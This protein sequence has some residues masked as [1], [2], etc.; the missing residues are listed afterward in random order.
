MTRFHSL[1]A[2]AAISAVS[3]PP[4]GSAQSSFDLSSWGTVDFYCYVEG[5]TSDILHLSHVFGLQKGDIPRI[6]PDQVAKIFRL[7]VAVNGEYDVGTESRCINQSE[8]STDRNEKAQNSR[9]WGT[10]VLNVAW[11][12]TIDPIFN[13]V[14]EGHALY[15]CSSSFSPTKYISQ[16]FSVETAA[17]ISRRDI[18]NWED[19]FE[20]YLETTYPTKSFLLFNTVCKRDYDPLEYA[21]SYSSAIKIGS[22]FRGNIIVTGWTP[23]NT[24]TDADKA[25]NPLN[26]FD[27]ITVRRF[28]PE[29]EVCVRDHEC[30]DGD[31][32]RVSV[33]ETV[34][35][36][37][38]ITNEPVCRDVQVDKGENIVELYAINGSGLKGNC[39]YADV[40]T[41]Q[42]TVQGREGVQGQIWKHRGKAGS[43]A[44]LPVELE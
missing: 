39:N 5:E 4:A 31:L 22:L 40:N 35:F 19:Q 30:E 44:I 33:N 1:I 34:I 43:S 32:I 7:Y 12:P 20:E 37:G 26:D 38:E 18:D 2:L 6:N 21:A 27:T 17:D 15:Y 29:V 24:D 16:P 9:R 11:T 25:S 28:S 14:F 41:G 10:T 8:S 13:T 36:E 23:E 3:L 42:I